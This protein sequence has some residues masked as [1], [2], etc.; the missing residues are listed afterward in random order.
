MSD[1]YRIDSHKLI[2]HPERVGKWL[3]GEDI[4]PIYI[5]IAPSGTC[6]HR[7]IFCALDYL[8][9]KPVFLDR[10]MIMSNL[11]EMHKKGVKSVMYAGEGEPLL[12]KETP[13]IVKETKQMGIDVAMTSNGVFFSKETAMECLDAFSWI[14]FSVNA[15]TSENYQ[16]IH[17]GKKNDFDKVI[18][19]IQNAVEIKKSNKLKTT[20]GVQLLLIPENTDDVLLFAKQLKEI[21]VDYFSV[22][23]F[24]QHPKSIC[25]IE[26]HFDYEKHLALESELNEIESERFNIIFRSNAMKKLKNERQYNRCLG[27]PFWSY[28]DANGNV[29]A[30][31]AYL[32]DYNYCF[33]NLKD[34]TF[35]EIW[36]GEQR[37]KIINSID[38][39]QCR[40]ICRLDEINIYLNQLKH[41]NDHAN[42]I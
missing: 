33:G 2:Y 34:N 36:E 32:G 25:H 21:G 35:A 10:K 7:C 3:N 30:C 4:Y 29:W 22:K 11:R 9:Y 24:S 27:N 13:A 28:I 16:K 19:N 8:E 20:I 6:N 39:I 15:G 23:P 14:R 31:S 12:N 42:F 41:P 5:E 26:E 37:K 17:K 38:V 18:T 40:E 1:N